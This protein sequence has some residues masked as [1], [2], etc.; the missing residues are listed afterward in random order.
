V[1]GKAAEGGNTSESREKRDEIESMI[2]ISMK[3]RCR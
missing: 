3:V 1:R 2:C